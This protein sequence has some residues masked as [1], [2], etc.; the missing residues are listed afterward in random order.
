MERNGLEAINDLEVPIFGIEIGPVSAERSDV[1]TRIEGDD[2]DAA[3]EIGS[4]IAVFVQRDNLTARFTCFGFL[5]DDKIAQWS[6][7]PCDGIGVQEGDSD[8]RHHSEAELDCLVRHGVSIHLERKWIRRGVTIRNGIERDGVVADRHRQVD[9]AIAIFASRVAA[10]GTIDGH[11]AA[12][13]GQTVA[14]FVFEDQFE[15]G[16]IAGSATAK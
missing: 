16:Q 3:I 13:S 8:R 1:A 14:R 9:R 2:H 5:P 15:S 12:E 6:W 11:A 10:K 7:I 4:S